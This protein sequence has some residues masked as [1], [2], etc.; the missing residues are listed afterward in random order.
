M[1]ICK[2]VLKFSEKSS[3]TIITRK[4]PLYKFNFPEENKLLYLYHETTV[5]RINS[6]SKHG[7]IIGSPRRE[8]S[9][10]AYSRTDLRAIFAS[11]SDLDTRY[12][13]SSSRK[14]LVIITLNNLPNTWYLDVIATKNSKCIS[15]MT[16]ENIP[17]QFI[18]IERL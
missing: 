13:I 12:A 17:P 4:V 8:G 10:I 9:P 1:K 11:Y 5:D 15:I 7:L 14:A 3:Q 2:D 6:I 16:F 18:A